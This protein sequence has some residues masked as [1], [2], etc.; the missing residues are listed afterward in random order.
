M[1]NKRLMVRSIGRSHHLCCH[2]NFTIIF[3]QHYIL[4]TSLMIDGSIYPYVSLLLCYSCILK[5]AGSRLTCLNCI[6]VCG[7]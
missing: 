6:F 5:A 1:G 7:I 3:V 2:D 4:L